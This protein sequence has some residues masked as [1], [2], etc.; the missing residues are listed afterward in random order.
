MDLAARAD[1]SQRYVSF[2]ETGRSRPGAS[3]VQRVAEA[4]E[5]PLRDRNILL[6]TAGLAP[7]YPEV[8]LSDDAVEPFRNTIRKMLES[9]D[10]Y[11]A[12]VINR[13]WDLI[14]ANIAGRR[15]FPEAGDG[16]I[17][18]VDTMLGPG[19]A[20]ERVDNFSAVAP[21]FLRRIRREVADSG[22]DERLQQL[23]TRAEAYMKDVLVDVI[24]AGADLVVCPHFRIGDQVI[25]TVSMVARFGTA[26]EVTLDEL[27]VELVFPRDDEADAFFRQSA[28]EPLQEASS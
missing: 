27:R 22:P 13:W 5:I 20:R 9:H 2:I 14:D 11:P 15:F 18:L 7:I 10:P 28:Q 16:P 21:V 12:Y 1:L 25:K 17:N 6:Q 26:R 3:V 19:P 23:L 8:P 4:L 24:D